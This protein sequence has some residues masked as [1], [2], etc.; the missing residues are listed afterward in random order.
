MEKGGK[1]ISVVIPCYN[2]EMFVGQAIESVFN[3]TFKDFEVVVVDDASTDK[4]PEAINWGQMFRRNVRYVRNEENLGIGGTRARGVKEARGEYLCFLSADDL[5]MPNYLEEMLKHADRKSFLFSDYFVI[6][7]GGEI[8]SLFRAP[9]F[10]SY[11]D[12]VINSVVQARNNTM[13]VCYNLFGPTKLFKENN[14]DE[15]LRFGE[16]LEHLLRCM[17]V[18]RIKFKHVPLPLFKYRMHS[19]MVTQQ[20]RI[21]KISENNQ[22]IFQKI[23]KLL[24]RKV[25]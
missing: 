22:R 21:Q 4:S 25:I 24:G 5:F 15:T 12:F 2:A 18:K 10:K 14:F 23:N 17:L 9:E 3:Q 20:Q 19:G 8:I 11:E 16:D 13:S 7:V 1:M 6:N